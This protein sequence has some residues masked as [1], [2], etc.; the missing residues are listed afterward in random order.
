MPTPIPGIPHNTFARYMIWG[1]MA[2]L[3]IYNWRTGEIF[4]WLSLQCLQ[5]KSP[6]IQ[7]FF[8]SFST[9]RPTLVLA[10]LSEIEH[11]ATKRVAE[12]DRADI[13]HTWFDLVVP[14]ATLGLKTSDKHFR[15]QRRLWSVIM[16]PRFL[17][18]TASNSFA[19]ATGQL[20]DLWTRKA[21]LGGADHAFEAQEDIR[22]ATL[23]GVWNMCCGSSLGLLFARKEALQQP[24]VVKRKNSLTVTF[25]K[26]DM[27]RFYDALQGLLTGL[28]WIIQ[29]ISPRVYKFVFTYSGYLPRVEK[30]SRIILDQ[31][32]ATARARVATDSNAPTCALEEVLRK[33]MRQNAGKPSYAV[34]EDALRSELLE[35]L[36]TGQETTASAIAWALKY[37]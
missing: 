19:D 8:P 3:G 11:I 24:S 27:P 20:A 28:D 15:E 14:K 6:L 13:M 17:A 26:G 5:L 22:M 25:A 23:D 36:V 33:D 21:E 7:V 37:L 32:I 16:S 1:D 4:S 31:C 34:S 2:K 10:D 35:L 9:N 18:G 12:I 29:G 30:E